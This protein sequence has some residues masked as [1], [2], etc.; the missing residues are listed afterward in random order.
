M[1]DNLQGVQ[2]KLNIPKKSFDKALEVL[3]KKGILER[4]KDPEGKETK[5]ISAYLTQYPRD[6]KFKLTFEFKII[7]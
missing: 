4:V 2:K 5:N 6:S 7:D 3:F 1:E